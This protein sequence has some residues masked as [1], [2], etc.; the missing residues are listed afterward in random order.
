ME[1]LFLGNDKFKDTMV[2]LAVQCSMSERHLKFIAKACDWIAIKAPSLT[3]MREMREVAHL[4]GNLQIVEKD[5]Q[6]LLGNNQEL[7]A[8]Q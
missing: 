8:D 1:S 2:K 5:N 3:D 7:R 6:R 4:Y